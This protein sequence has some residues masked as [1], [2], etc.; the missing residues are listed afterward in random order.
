M[1]STLPTFLRSRRRAPF[2]LAGSP[3]WLS[4]ACLLWLS[5]RHLCSLCL[6]NL[7]NYLVSLFLGPLPS[8][9]QHHQRRFFSSLFPLLS[10]SAS[11]TTLHPFAFSALFLLSYRS[12]VPI[13][14]R[15]EVIA[16][17][18]SAIKTTQ[19]SDTRDTIYD[20]VYDTV[21]AF[22]SIGGLAVFDPILRHSAIT[23]LAPT[24]PTRKTC[25]RTFAFDH[26]IRSSD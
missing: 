25:P 23:S 4:P 2:L 12:L 6:F 26:L 9:T 18:A 16:K 19:Q 5:T 7:F 22:P 24:A 8:K 10:V 20:D 3:L 13:C 17:R 1:T 15:F 21:L 11:I 14:S